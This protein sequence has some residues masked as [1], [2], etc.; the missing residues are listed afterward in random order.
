MITTSCDAR[1]KLLSP[2]LGEVS[3][4]ENE[5]ILFPEGLI[6]FEEH[7]GFLMVDVR[8][9]EPIQWIMSVDDPAISLPV[10]NPFLIHQQY[11]PQPARDEI[12]CI[13]LE[14]IRQARLYTVVTVSDESSQ[15]SINLRGPILI[16]DVRKLGKQ[17]VLIHSDYSLKYPINL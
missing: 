11:D 14:S 10:I 3:F 9:F 5:I 7:T 4:R 12:L 6:G 2:V 15:V 16:N 1:R 13:G 8:G 17:V